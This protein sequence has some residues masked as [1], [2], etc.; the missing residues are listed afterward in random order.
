MANSNTG[1]FNMHFLAQVIVS[2]NPKEIST[3]YVNY[4]PLLY[5]D[6]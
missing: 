2:Y 3:S 4:F 6:F 5:S 1:S